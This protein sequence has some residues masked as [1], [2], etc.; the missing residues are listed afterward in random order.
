MPTIVGA[1]DRDLMIGEASDKNALF[2]QLGATADQARRLYDPLG[3]QSLDALKQ[4]VFA[5]RTRVEPAR[6]FADAMARAS[7]PVYL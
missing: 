4:R 3:V 7:Q 5:D 6:R 2:A 1:N